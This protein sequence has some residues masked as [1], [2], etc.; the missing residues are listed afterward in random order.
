MNL[1]GGVLRSWVSFYRLNLNDL[2][3]IYDDISLD[4]G[5][6]RL[7]EAGSSGGHKGM[8]SIIQQMSSELVP[9]LRLGVGPRPP[10][11]DLADYVLHPFSRSEQET[12]KNVISLVPE[13]VMC[14]THE[15]LTTGMN[16]YN[17][18]DTRA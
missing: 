17:G 7:R 1:S 9:R 13:I 4:L 5:R 12:V 8:L 14:W 16:R 10:H 3:V 15:G 6:I 11:E 2:L 18:H